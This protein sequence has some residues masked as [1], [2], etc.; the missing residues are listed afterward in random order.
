[1][2]LFQD[3]IPNKAGALIKSWMERDMEMTANI[4]LNNQISSDMYMIVTRW[5]FVQI[6]KNRDDITPNAEF[7][8]YDYKVV[9]TINDQLTTKLMIRQH[10]TFAPL[11]GLVSNYVILFQDVDTKDKFEDLVGQFQSTHAPQT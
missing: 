9:N 6:Y 1:M 5:G 7:Y 8:V 3:P 11:R 2:F 10:Q 4:R